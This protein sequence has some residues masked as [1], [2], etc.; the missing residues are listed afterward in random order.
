MQAKKN[1][2]DRRWDD[3]FDYVFESE[4]LTFNSSRY[5]DGITPLEIITCEKPDLSEYLDFGSYDWFTYRNKAVLGVPEVGRWLGVSHQVGH[6]MS[7]WIL[8]KLGIPVSCTTVQ[9]ITNLENQTD[10]YISRMK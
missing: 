5:S 7:Y 8:P 6:L 4:I 3:G 1:I 9:R 10:E 2:H